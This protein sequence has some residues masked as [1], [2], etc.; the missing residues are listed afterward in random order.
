MSNNFSESQ[1]IKVWQNQLL[2]RTELVTEDGERIEI[3]YPGRLNDEQGADFRDAVIA[4][5]KGLLK[6]DIEIHVKSSDWKNH[7]HHQNPAYNRVILHVA[8]WNNTGT[9]TKLQNGTEVPILALNKH[10][11]ITDNQCPSPTSCLITSRVPCLNI[12]QR[13]NGQTITELL[14][15][16]GEERFFNKVSRFRGDLNKTEANQSLY[17]GI[18]E[19]LGYSKNKLPFFE[20]ARRLPIHILESIGKRATS[21]R[22]CLI[23]HQALLL[24]IAGLL[25]TQY[26]KIYRRNGINDRWLEKLVQLWA[27][28]PYT[29]TMSFSDWNLFKV[30]PNNSPVRRLVAMSY[31]LLRYREKGLLPG[32]V[33]LIEDVPENGGYRNLEEGLQ[34]TIDGYQTSHHN[35][36]N[37][38]RTGCLPL[39]GG[40]RAADI[41][42]NVLLPFTFAWGQFS[43]QP[44]L[45]NKAMDIYRL[46]PRLAVNSVE[47][48]MS[49]QLGLSCGMVKLA[50]C[51][52]GLIHIYKKMCTQGKCHKCDLSQLEAGNYIQV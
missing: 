41:I 51:Q 23:Q 1:L 16:F 50:K 14:A 26:Q 18:M 40:S 21:D 33:H 22:E 20:L 43:S 17:Q 19:A 15:R 31:L 25:P 27:S 38:N 7:C 48:H 39:L 44:E 52:Q 32:L 10:T 28:L 45:S 12:V 47:K 4:T 9:N 46:Y 49:G 3:I 13:L 5:S 42:V 24:G 30:R 35:F 29:K 37:S 6:G 36:Y 2:D 34:V 8:M 11:E